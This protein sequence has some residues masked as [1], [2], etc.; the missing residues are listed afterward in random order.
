[1]KDEEGD[2]KRRREE[3]EFRISISPGGADWLRRVAQ[4]GKGW[5]TGNPKEGE[6]DGEDSSQTE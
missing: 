6:K 5:K 4:I 3:L 1:M 2:R